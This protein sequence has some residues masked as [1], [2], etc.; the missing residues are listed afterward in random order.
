VLF[1]EQMVSFGLFI[2][3]IIGVFLGALL[4]GAQGAMGTLLGLLFVVMGIV[5]FVMGLRKY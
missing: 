2:A 5:V 3:G 4:I 1:G